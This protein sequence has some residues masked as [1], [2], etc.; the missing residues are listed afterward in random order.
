M[1]LTNVRGSV[2]TD[3]IP[4][5]ENFLSPDTMQNQMRLGGALCTLRPKY[6]KQSNER[7]GPSVRDRT[8]LIYVVDLPVFLTQARLVSCE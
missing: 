8:E 1:R 4:L 7:E 6:C 2:I 3:S 5:N